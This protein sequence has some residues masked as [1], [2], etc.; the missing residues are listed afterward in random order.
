MQ[1]KYAPYDAEY[2][3][4]LAMKHSLH[5]LC[6]SAETDFDR[7]VAITR[8][9]SNLWQHDGANQPEKDDPEFILN[10]VINGGKRFRCVEYATVV[11]GCLAALDVTARCLALKTEDAETR[12]S[13]AGHLVVEVY[14]GEHNKWVFIDTQWGVIPMIDGVPLNAVELAEC[15]KSGSVPEIIQLGEPCDSQDYFDWVEEYLFFYNYK[16][17]QEHDGHGEPKTIMLVPDGVTPPTVFQRKWP[18]KVDIYTHSVNEFYR[19]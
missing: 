4:N 18:L 19:L 14:L 1:T 2:L 6:E 3:Q 7:A 9:V 5:K 10:E 17:W 12:E 15:L 11:H 8:W 13:G 16:F